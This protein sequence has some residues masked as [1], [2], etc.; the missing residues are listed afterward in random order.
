MKI[1]SIALLLQKNVSFPYFVQSVPFFLYSEARNIVKFV[2][3]VCFLRRI[4]VGNTVLLN[5]LYP[6]CC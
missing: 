2:D 5:R 4:S 3:W 6:I 1:F